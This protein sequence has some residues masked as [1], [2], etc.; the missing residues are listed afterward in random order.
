MTTVS[1]GAL[2]RMLN[3]PANVVVGV[4]RFEEDPRG[5]AV[6]VV[7]VRPYANDADRCAGCGRRART[8]DRL[9]V[10]RR[11]HLDTG[12]ARLLLE[13]APPRVSCP[14]H[15]VRVAMVPWAGHG[16][17]FTHDFERQVAWPGVHASRSAV[18]TLMRV[19]WKSVGPICSRVADGLRAEQGPGLFDGLRSIGVDET[20]HRKGHR[21]MTVVVASCP[22]AYTTP[23]AGHGTA[24]GADP[25]PP[26]CAPCSASAR[27][28]QAHPRGTRRYRRTT[29]RPHGTRSTTISR[30]R[31]EYIRTPIRTPQRPTF[32]PHPNRSTIKLRPTSS[33]HALLPKPEK[34]T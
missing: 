4:P 31:L 29:P 10:R 19:D 26:T 30:K 33:R 1:A 27:R 25:R 13:H 11:R 21:Y 3:L 16:S 8:Y 32:R 28:H 18:S 34:T 9:G 2:K 17:R 20:S 14:E 23:P 6:V 12:C 22:P 5:G 24:H 15:G 7:P